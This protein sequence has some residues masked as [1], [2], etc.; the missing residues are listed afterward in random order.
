MAV[1]AGFNAAQTSFIDKLKGL[2]SIA[3]AFLILLLSKFLVIDAACADT[4]SSAGALLVMA[5]KKAAPRQ[6]TSIIQG[7]ASI[8]GG[9]M[10]K[11]VA[12]S[13]VSS[14]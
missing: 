2:N 5:A 12:I 6:A 4:L 14:L 13:V 1:Q 9:F 8:A 11:L 7:L 3:I 10:S